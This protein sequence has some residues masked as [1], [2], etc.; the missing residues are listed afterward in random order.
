MAS[1]TDYGYPFNSITGDRTYNASAWRDYYS[2]LFTNGVIPDDLNELVVTESD[3]S[4]KTVK[5]DTG[6][7]IINGAIFSL[8]ASVD[9][10]VDDNASGSVRID[11]VIARLDVTN[12]LME[13]VIL[14]GTAGAGTPALTQTAAVWEES[15]AQISLANGFTTIADAVI[16]DERVYAETTVMFNATQMNGELPDFYL[17]RANH[18]GTQTS[19]TISNFVATV[20]SSVLT[21]LSFVSGAVISATDTILGALGKLQKQITTNKE[22]AD[23]HIA[24]TTNPHDVNKTDVGLGSVLNYGVATQTEAE[25]GTVSTEYMTPLRTK[26]AINKAGGFGFTNLSAAED[27]TNG[28][29]SAT[30]QV[31][32]GD[33]TINNTSDR[34]ECNKNGYVEIIFSARGASSFA[35]YYTMVIYKNGTQIQSSKAEGSDR[36]RIAVTAIV[37]TSVT[38]G[39]YI[40]FKNISNFGIA[41]G[42]ATIKYVV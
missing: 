33:I 24:D 42:Q 34:F 25:A 17:A 19:S 38:S 3:I 8:I 1:L 37:I 31:S 10:N 14:K 29:F 21:G 5:V 4:A 39:D 26:Q 22:T 9:L 28:I 30:A 11:R 16:T 36:E 35:A 32:S 23:T 13:V 27:T 15:L 7:V 2:K 40:E 18:T 41:D 20:R 6:T 12:R